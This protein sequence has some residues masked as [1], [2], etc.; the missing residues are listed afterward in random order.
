MLQEC[1]ADVGANAQWV[2]SRQVVRHVALDHAFGG[3]NPPSPATLAYTDRNG[4]GG[5]AALIGPLSAG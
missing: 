1:G 4:A 5:H 2:G 3:S